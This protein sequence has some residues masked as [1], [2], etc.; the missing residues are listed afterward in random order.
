[1]AR[2]ARVCTGHMWQTGVTLLFCYVTANGPSMARLRNA[3]RAIIGRLVFANEK[4]CVHVLVLSEQE[5]TL[6]FY[7]FSS[8]HGP[9]F[10]TVYDRWKKNGDIVSFGGGSP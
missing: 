2:L 8:S 9:F 1:M 10:V 7:S 5:H 6:N 3:A 4:A